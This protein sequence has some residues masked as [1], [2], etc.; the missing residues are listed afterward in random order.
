VS[1]IL[2]SV[3]FDKSSYAPGDIVNLTVN[4]TSS[5]VQADPGAGTSE[6]A[7]QLALTDTAGTLSPPPV[8]YFIDTPATEPQPVSVSA[9]ETIDAP[10]APD[11]GQPTGRTWALSSNTLLTFDAVTGTSTWEATLW[12]QIPL[13]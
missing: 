3:T 12:V 11:N 9:T 1:I 6:V 4:Y 8:G 13:D 10:E 2:T 5:D 7:V